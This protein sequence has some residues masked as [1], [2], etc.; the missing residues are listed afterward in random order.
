[1]VDFMWNMQIFNFKAV[2]HEA[3]NLV[4]ATF[5]LR[6]NLLTLL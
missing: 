6:Y 1:M 3:E 5:Y 4:V 2:F